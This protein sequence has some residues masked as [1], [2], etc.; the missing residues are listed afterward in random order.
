[1]WENFDFSDYSF[2][3]TC[4]EVACGLWVG[5]ENTLCSTKD[6]MRGGRVCIYFI[7]L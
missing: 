7:Y 1:M 3:S 2:F 5:K 4:N 6:N